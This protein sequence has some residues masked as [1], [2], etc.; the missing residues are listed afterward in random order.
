[1][2]PAA[3]PVKPDKKPRLLTDF[4]KGFAMMTPPRNIKPWKDSESESLHIPG[5]R[6]MAQSEFSFEDQYNERPLWFAKFLAVWG[7]NN[8]VAALPPLSCNFSVVSI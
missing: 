5:Q 8:T 7:I 1:M 4:R 3:V 6:R 2:L